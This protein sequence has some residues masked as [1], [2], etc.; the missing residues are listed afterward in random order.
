MSRVG[1]RFRL[2]RTATRDLRPADHLSKPSAPVRIVGLDCV[3]DAAASL[4]KSTAQ[5]SD[6]PQAEA[7][8]A[9][10]MRQRVESR[11]ME[12]GVP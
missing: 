1:H 8:L 6:S 5:L 4:E 11:A 12:S 9:V 2:P 3:V 7:A 10:L